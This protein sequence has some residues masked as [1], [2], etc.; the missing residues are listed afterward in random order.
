MITTEAEAKELIHQIMEWAKKEY[1]EGEVPTGQFTE[2]IECSVEP[3]HNQRRSPLDMSCY[4]DEWKRD[5][6]IT[7]FCYVCGAANVVRT[8]E[9]MNIDPYSAK[10]QDLFYEQ[11]FSVPESEKEQHEN[12]NS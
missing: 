4:I 9:I 5:K 7:K 1:G 11:L 3:K 10:V 8:V 2:F 12:A 6:E